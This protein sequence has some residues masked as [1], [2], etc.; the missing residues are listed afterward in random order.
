MFS[1]SICL[2]A[3]LISLL[4]MNAAARAEAVAYQSNL[5]I[6]LQP[7]AKKLV[8]RAEMVVPAPAGQDL[9]FSIAPQTKIKSV[10]IDGLQVRHKLQGGQLTLPDTPTSAGRS[11]TVTVSYEAEFADTIPEDPISFDNPGYGVTAS[12]SERGTFLLPGSGW[13][14]QGPGPIP[15][16]ELTVIAPRGIYAVTAGRLVRHEDHETTSISLWEIDEPLEGLALSAGPYVIHSQVAGTIPVMTY[17][18]PQSAGLADT[19]LQAAG[20]HLQFY[21]ALHGPYPFP[22]FAV[23]ENFFPTGYGFP[24]YTLLGSSV[25]NLPFIPETSLRHEVA[26]SWW[27]NGVFVDYDSG[28]WCEGLTTYVADYLSQERTSPAEGR[29]YRQQ[30]LQDYATLVSAGKDFPLRRFVSRVDPATRAVGYGKAAFVFHMVRHRLGD[31]RFW[32]SLRQVFKARLFQKTSWD[33]F[34][35]VFIETGSWEPHEAERFF[36]Q[37][38]DRAGAPRLQLQEVHSNSN[39]TGWH[40]EGLLAQN[41]PPY[42]LDAVLRLQSKT[43]HRD[44]SVR[45]T[46]PSRSFRI[47]PEEAPVRLLADPD[48]N[49]FRLLYPEEIP[50]TVNSIKG[51]ADLVAVFS[52]A[53][54]P[55]SRNVFAMLLA[56]LGQDRQPIL[57]E[58][59]VDV[60]KMHSLDFIFF[61][62]PR[63]EAL[64]ALF[65]SKPE[66]LL[67]AAERFELPG[68]LSSDTAD[69]LFAAFGDPHRA[70]KLTALFLPVAGAD[71]QSVSTAARKITHYGKYSYLAFRQGINQAKGTWPVSRSPLVV[72]F[73]ESP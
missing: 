51:A 48:S 32:L 53:L 22:K 33:D 65:A 18:F 52:D 38:L 42:D 25:L 44:G 58:K 46:G 21:E 10:A 13:Y 37:W 40:V 47:D 72:N 62:W 9:A 49:L 69:C 26:H 16:V 56:S 31:D 11:L 4:I 8:G 6:E 57:P 50:A 7:A 70:G 3:G 59:D 63:S 43:G 41:A 39:G 67:L 35:R 36:E 54:P 71:S 27:G 28:N 20:A 55:A 34:R 15:K 17:F 14:P 5:S 61:G 60:T 73:K 29:Q 12:I 1:K 19:Y 45:L 64:R 2:M 68:V 23:V 66:G 24:S 30:I